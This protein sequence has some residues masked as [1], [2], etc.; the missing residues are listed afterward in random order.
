M[1]NAKGETFGFTW[2]AGAMIMG[3]ARYDLIEKAGLGMPKTFDDLIK[4]CD[5]VHNKEGVAAF[6][7]DKLHHWNWI[8]YLMGAG[9]SGVQGAAGQPDADARHA[10]G[11]RRRPSG[12]PTC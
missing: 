7:A 4:V 11:R 9:G 10:A 12:T 6:T 1:K 2:E 5:A 3:A 8:P